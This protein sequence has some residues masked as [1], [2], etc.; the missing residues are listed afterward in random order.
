VIHFVVLFGLFGLAYG[1]GFVTKNAYLFAVPVVMAGIYLW[2][3]VPADDDDGSE[4]R[5]VRRPG[6]AGRSR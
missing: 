1:L 6:A 4:A 2:H 5:P 3:V